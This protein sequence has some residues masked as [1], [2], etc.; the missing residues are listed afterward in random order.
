MATKTAKK[1]TKKEETKV[2]NF[3]NGVFIRETTFE[4]GNTIL[5]IDFNA[6]QFCDTMKEHM[7]ENGYFRATIYRNT[8]TDS[9]YSHNMRINNYSP[10]QAAVEA[11]GEMPF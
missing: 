4:D 6:K 8:N 11:I 10:K 1:T 3:V 5:N 9:K 7:R 2:T